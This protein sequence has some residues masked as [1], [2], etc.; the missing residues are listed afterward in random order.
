MVSMDIGIWANSEETVEDRGAWC[1]SIS[2]VAKRHT[3]LREWVS[4]TTT[5]EILHPVAR[6]LKLKQLTILAKLS[7]CVTSLS[8]LGISSRK[9]GHQDLN[10]QEVAHVFWVIRTKIFPNG[11]MMTY[12][13][14]SSC[15]H[16]Q[17]PNFLLPP[18]QSGIL[19]LSLLV[20]HKIINIKSW[21]CEHSHVIWI[22]LNY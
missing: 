5:L 12:P 21:A 7:G 1:A 2:G 10:Y 18:L 13:F 8:R 9:N 3:G 6:A 4:K 20:I 19:C 17:F 15:L 14:C 11:K 16:V 22:L